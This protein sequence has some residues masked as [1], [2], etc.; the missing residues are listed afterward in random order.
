MSIGQHG[1]SSPATSERIDGAE[2]PCPLWDTTHGI[3][4]LARRQRVAPIVQTRSDSQRCC[5]VSSHCTDFIG[6]RRLT[7]AAFR[8]WLVRVMPGRAVWPG[9]FSGHGPTVRETHSFLSGSVR[10]PA[11]HS[12]N[13]L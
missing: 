6:A 11:P 9:P 7:F 1:G 5:T 12:P 10:F 2:E 4:V 3:G 13:R 8:A